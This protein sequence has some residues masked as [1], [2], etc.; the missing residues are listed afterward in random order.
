[1]ANYKAKVTTLQNNLGALL[2][3]KKALNS[4]VVSQEYENFK[5]ASDKVLKGEAVPSDVRVT[6][7]GL[8]KALKKEGLFKNVKSGFVHMKKDFLLSSTGRTTSRPPDP[9]V[10]QRNT[11]AVLATRSQ[12]GSRRK[13]HSNPSG[14]EVKTPSGSEVKNLN[15]AVG[16]L[17]DHL[18]I[19]KLSEIARESTGLSIAIARPSTPPTK[20]ADQ[21]DNSD[22]F[23]DI[24]RKVKNLERELQRQKASQSSEIVKLKEENRYLR[25]A[26]SDMSKEND[27]LK[28]LQPITRAAKGKQVEQIEKEYNKQKRGIEGKM[29]EMES[30]LQINLE[31]T[32]REKEDL[33]HMIMDGVSKLKLSIS[34][35]HKRIVGDKD[36]KTKTT[37]TLYGEDYEKR[38][39]DDLIRK[40]AQIE[41][42]AELLEEKNG[43][44]GRI[45]TEKDSE[46]S[47][48]RDA[49]LQITEEVSKLHGSISHLYTP[50]EPNKSEKPSVTFSDPLRRVDHGVDKQE[51]KETLKKIQTVNTTIQ[52]YKRILKDKERNTSSPKGNGDLIPLKSQINK[53]HDDLMKLVDPALLKENSGSDKSDESREASPMS[54]R[55]RADEINHLLKKLNRVERACAEM[56]SLYDSPM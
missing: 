34:A 7:T 55:D 9:D 56:K 43:S 35:L 42:E 4:R 23:K 37:L 27:R 45:L 29:R 18:R 25:T 41:I 31:Q 8:E 49:L 54:Q 51:M 13:L 5:E 44:L 19:Q 10:P 16:K 17:Y 26:M 36:E 14:A 47:E 22:E 38:S 24:I 6:L 3:Q 15:R 2:A 28:G 52:Q 46:I 21:S 33:E 48:L 20:K 11:T 40:I 12:S 53:I 30:E 50:E 1:M 39:I 32:L